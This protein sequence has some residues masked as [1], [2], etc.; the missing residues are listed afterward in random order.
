MVNYAI[1]KTGGKQ[2][3]VEPGK[4]YT[5]E[6]LPGDAGSAVTF[7]AVLCTFTEGGSDVA[8]GTPILPIT[9]TGTVVEQGRARKIE[10]IKYK[11]KSRYRRHFGHRQLQTKVKIEAIG[12]PA[13]T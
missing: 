4:T 2:Y 7:D 11:A 13:T 12:T 9:V 8:V 5:F 3:I 10:G 6:K 1:I